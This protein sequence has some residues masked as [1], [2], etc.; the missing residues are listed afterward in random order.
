MLVVTDK[1]LMDLKL[2]EG[3]LESLDE[4]KTRKRR[5]ARY[6]LAIIGYSIQVVH[7]ISE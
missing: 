6:L 2:P 3:L 1:V 4:N 7:I 5:T